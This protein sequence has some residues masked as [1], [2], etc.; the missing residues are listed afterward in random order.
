MAHGAGDAQVVALLNRTLRWWPPTR[1]VHLVADRGFPSGALVQVL[2]RWQPTLPRGY[3]VRLRAGDHGSLANG[4]RQRVGERLSGAVGEWSIA[5]ARSPRTPTRTPLAP[6][7]P[8][9][10]RH[11]APTWVVVGRGPR[12]V[13]V[14]QSGPADQRR[15]AE[16]ARARQAP[17]RSKGQP[18]ALGTDHVGAL[19]TTEPDPTCALAFYQRRCAIEPTYRD[20]KGWDLEAVVARETDADVVD[21]L[22]GLAALASCVQLSLGHAAGHTAD[23]A[24]GARQQPWSTTDRLSLAWRGRHVLHDRAHDWRPWLEVTLTELYLLLAP[25]TAP[26]PRAV[27]PPPLLQAGA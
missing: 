2:A 17:L 26:L 8:G 20:L 13:P 22:L 16:R 24:A 10:R 21:G 11:P 12:G 5:P 6:A 1:P 23:P 15:R 9:P 27:P 3:T 14:P 4:T 18:G 7:P 25:T 19:L